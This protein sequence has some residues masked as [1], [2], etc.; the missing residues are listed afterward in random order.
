MMKWPHESLD[1][2]RFADSISFH[3]VS[4]FTP[5]GFRQTQ[6]HRHADRQA[7]KAGRHWP[8]KL[9]PVLLTLG[10]G[11]ETPLR[12]LA[13]STPKQNYVHMYVCMCICHV[14][15]SREKVHNVRRLTRIS[16]LALHV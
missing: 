5:L 11:A 6:T 14:S 8:E 7:G 9:K 13:L 4:L 1:P 10:R 2:T 3:S 15:I 16:P 12:T